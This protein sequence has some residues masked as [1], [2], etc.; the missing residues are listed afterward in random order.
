MNDL[1]IQGRPACEQKENLWPK[2]ILKLH[3]IRSESGKSVDFRSFN[4]FFPV[5]FARSALSAYF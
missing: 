3:P 4:S 1:L 2:L 5:F